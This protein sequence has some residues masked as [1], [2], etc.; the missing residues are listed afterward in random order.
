MNVPKEQVV[1]KPVY[2][3]ES[4][5]KMSEVSGLLVTLQ[6]KQKALSSFLE[7]EEAAKFPIG[8]FTAFDYSEVRLVLEHRVETIKNQLRSYGIEVP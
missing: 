1:M 8:N 3:F 5:E 6:E 2:K 4:I 7:M